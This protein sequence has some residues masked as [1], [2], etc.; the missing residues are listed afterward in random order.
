MTVHLGGSETDTTQQ[1]AERRSNRHTK[2]L[3]YSVDSFAWFLG[4]IGQSRPSY[5]HSTTKYHSFIPNVF[6]SRLHTPPKF[7][8]SGTVAA[9]L[10]LR[11]RL[12]SVKQNPCK[13][14]GLY[15]KP[16][17]GHFEHDLAMFVTACQNVP[18]GDTHTS[19][20]YSTDTLGS[21]LALLE[22]LGGNV[23]FL[24]WHYRLRI[25]GIPATSTRRPPQ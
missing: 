18:T 2:H 24:I 8:H 14:L 16:E 12:L 7:V 20:K 10:G 9:R 11:Q 21:I 23:L 4:I 3:L 1:G 6:T 15:S 25:G 17:S 19:G 22:W 5:R 13:I